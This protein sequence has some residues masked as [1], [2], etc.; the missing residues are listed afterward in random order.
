MTPNKISQTAAFLAVKFYG[1]SRD[2]QFR[3]LF[4]DTVI[5]FYDRLVYSL[6]APIRYYH[7]WLKFSGIRKLYIWS[8][9]LLLP[10][11]LLHIIGRKWVIHHMTQQLIDEGYKQIVVLGSGF[12]HLGYYFCQQGINCIECDTPHMA[13]RKRTFLHN[14][15]P[16][17]EHPVILN[18][19]LPDDN[20]DDVFTNEQQIHPDKKTV[21]VAEGFFDY[22]TSETVN[23][24]LQQISSYFSRTPAL[25]S[26][27]FALDELSMFHRTVFRRS[28]EMV[29]EKLQFEASMDAFRNLLSKGGFQIAELHDSRAIRA[30]IHSQITTTLPMLNGF[31]I[32]RTKS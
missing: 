8:E 24:S 1:L 26:T 15:Y 5:S 2:E 4:D 18:T 30:K 11:D 19:Y 28:V 9:E 10:G 13:H 22:L 25:I 27:H 23:Q 32:F 3:S 17:S 31:Y 20:L 6:P 7:F 16:K 12:D 21:V 14:S 29:G